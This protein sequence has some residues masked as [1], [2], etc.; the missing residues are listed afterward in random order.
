MDELRSHLRRALLPDLAAGEAALEQFRAEFFRFFPRLKGNFDYPLQLRPAAVL[1]PVVAHPGAPTVLLTYRT[2]DMPT[3]PG[4]IVFPG[5]GV[6]AGDADLLDTALRETEEEIGL[7]RA[8]IEVA[9]FLDARPM[10]TRHRVQPVLGL[11]SPEAQYRPCERE[12]AAIF[13]VPLAVV[14]DPKQY[15]R[16]VA[17]PVYGPLPDIVSLDYGEHRIWGATADILLDLCGKWAEA[18]RP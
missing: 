10:G 5:G 13:E 12:V 6:K 11:V 15:G 18:G 8:Q 7:E 2:D 1:V 14:L 17:D 9:G 16:G 4:E 3:H